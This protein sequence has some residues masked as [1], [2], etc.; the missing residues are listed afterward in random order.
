MTGEHDEHGDAHEQGM[1]LIDINI[2]TKKNLFNLFIF[3]IC[4]MLFTTFLEKNNFSGPPDNVVKNKKISFHVFFTSY[5]ISHIYRE[6]LFLG[7]G[8]RVFLSKI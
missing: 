6:K 4:F 5:A 7:V 2:K 8:G 3:S 1:W